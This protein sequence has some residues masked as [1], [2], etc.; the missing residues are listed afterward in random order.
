M[1]KSTWLRDRSRSNEPLWLA[2]WL[3]DPAT[4]Y[5]VLALVAGVLL[6]I[7]GQSLARAGWWL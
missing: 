4:V 6:E 7:V 3:T 5:C 1:I 2:R